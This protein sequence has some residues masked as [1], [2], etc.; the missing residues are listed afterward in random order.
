MLWFKLHQTLCNYLKLFFSYDLFSKM[1]RRGYYT[2]CKD[3]NNMLAIKLGSLFYPVDI[4]GNPS[5][6]SWKISEKR[7]L[8]Q[9]T[10]F[11]ALTFSCNSSFLILSSW[12]HPPTHRLHSPEHPRPFCNIFSAN[13]MLTIK[14]SSPCFKTG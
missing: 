4:V 13:Y 3:Q 1:V 11:C 14:E 12:Q 2:I 10:I 5:E 7:S 9:K 8:V 6:Q